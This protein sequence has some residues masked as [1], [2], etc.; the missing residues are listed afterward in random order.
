[1]PAKDSRSPSHC[2]RSKRSPGSEPARADHDEEWR[3]VD[4]QRGA[5]GVGPHQPPEDQNELQGEQQAGGNAGNERAV[6]LHQL[7]AAAARPG[8]DDERTEGRAE[9]GLDQRRNLRQRELDRDLIEAPAQAK[10]DREHGRDGIERP[11]GGRDVLF[12]GCR[13]AHSNLLPAVVIRPPAGS[14]LRPARGRAQADDPVFTIAEMLHEGD[15]LQRRWLL[16]ARL[17]G[18]DSAVRRAP[19]LTSYDVTPR[20]SGCRCR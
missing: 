15:P 19:S 4:E 16:G 8:H 17:R 14:G 10:H 7:H 9:R 13:Y 2:Q 18:H 1:M 11:G 20:G 6:G 5:A 3:S 12:R